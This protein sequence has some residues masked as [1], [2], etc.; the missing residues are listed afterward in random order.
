MNWNSHTIK[1]VFLFIF[2]GSSEELSM[3]EKCRILVCGG[4]NGAH[5]LSA[6]A[7]SKDNLDVHVLT[8]Y[9]DEAERWAKHVENENMKLTITKQDGTQYDIFS[10]PSLITK[11]AAKAMSGVEIVF[12]V[13]PAFAH[14]QYFTAIAPHLQPNTLIVGLPGQAGFELQCRHI[15]GDKAS[16][17]TIAASESLPFACRIVEF[18][19]HTRILGLKDS[20]GMSALKGKACQLSFPVVETVQGILGEYPKLEL[21][22][23]YIAINLMADANVHPPMMY[24]RWGNWDGKPLKE[25][26]L[27]Y[28][29]VDDR[30]ADLLSRVSEEL[31]AA[32]KA[33]EQKRKDVDMSEVIHLFDWYKIH[34]PDQIT[35]KSSLKMAMRTNKAYDGLVHP[36]VKTD[37]GYVPNFNYRYTSEDVPFGMVVMKGIADLAGVPTPAMDEILAWGQQKLGKEYIVGSKLIGKDI[38]LARAPQSFGMTSVD[39]LFD[40]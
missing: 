20:L 21:L 30:Q 7:A 14:A 34:Y 8:L 5:C 3:S 4:G 35:D 9:Q 39:E 23:N 33:I 6:L 28:Q 15:I 38:G 17:C 18:G 24:G 36:M 26:P 1:L 25:E 31:L 16:S 27:F 2:L 11:D 32:A 37:E 10:K 13:V 40:I 19:R 12:L 29:G 22:K